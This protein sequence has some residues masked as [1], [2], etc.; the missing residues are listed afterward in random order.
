MRIRFAILAVLLAVAGIVAHPL[1]LQAA[2]GRDAFSSEQKTGIESI[3]REYL[4]ANPEILKDMSQALQAREMKAMLEKASRQISDNRAALLADDLP[5]VGAKDGDVAIVQFFDYQCH[6]CKVVL[7]TVETLV[8][9]DPK[10][11]VV[12]VDFPILS[13]GSHVA[14]AAAV[15]AGLQGKYADLYPALMGYQGKL[16][17]A[18]IEKL[19]ASVGVDVERMKK[20]MESDAVKAR[21]EQ[22]TALA[23][24]IGIQGTPAFIVGD[25]LL[26]GAV[27]VEQFRR[28][29]ADI[30]SG[31]SGK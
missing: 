26:P 3:V 1:L 15:A 12:L 6:Y 4:L 18:T 21:L 29:I 27:P 13:E 17:Q 5:F 22:N 19:A 16:S 2:D 31:N 7:Q 24:K 8:K 28:M 30:R 14:S 25:Q 23:Q 9:E 11:K 20:D 10:L